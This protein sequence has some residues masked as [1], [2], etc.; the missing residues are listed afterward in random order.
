MT[1]GFLASQIINDAY[2]IIRDGKNGV[3]LDSGKA[4]FYRSDRRIV[5]DW[6]F[7]QTFRGHGIAAAHVIYVKRK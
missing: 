3:V 7:S 4:C 5:K 2:V 1:V 6:D